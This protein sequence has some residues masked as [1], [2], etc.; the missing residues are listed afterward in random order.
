MTGDNGVVRAVP[1]NGT[2]APSSSITNTRKLGSLSVSKTVVWNGVTAD[3]LQTFSICITGPAPSTTKQCQPVDFDGGTVTW[4]NLIPGDYTVSETNPGPEWSVT[5]DNGVVRA[6]PVNGA[7]APSSS[8]TNTR[9][10]GSLSVSKT[11]IWNG[12]TPIDGQTFSI[13]IRVRLRRRRSSA[14]R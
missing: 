2:S 7:S 5:G 12:V 10:L 1:V 9:K 6:V 4:N 8:V 3:P 14:S 11:V 13:C